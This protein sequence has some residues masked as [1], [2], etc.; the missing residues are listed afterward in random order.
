MM[1][2]PEAQS[3]FLG[4]SAWLHTVNRYPVVD[5][6]RL[7]LRLVSSDRMRLDS[8]KS[9]LDFALGYEVVNDRLRDVGRDSK[10]DPR[11]FRPHAR[12]V[13]ADDLAC[14]IDQGSAAIAGIDW[15]SVWMAP[16]MLVVVSGI[17]R[18]SR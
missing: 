17:T 4:R 5:P 13:D 2:S 16:L 6:Q 12:G 10:E 15:R 1:T 7:G 11:V 8:N 3:R 9:P 18:S 14:E